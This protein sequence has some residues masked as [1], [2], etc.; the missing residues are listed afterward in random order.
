[1]QEAIHRRIMVLEW[2]REKH[3]T[4]PEK[5]LKQKGGVGGLDQM[6]EHLPSK[7]KA[8]NLNPNIAKKKKKKTK[9]VGEAWWSGPSG[10][11]A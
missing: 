5:L 2:L 7:H 4:L 9:R 10:K 3:G 11:S 6:V 1:M 8:M